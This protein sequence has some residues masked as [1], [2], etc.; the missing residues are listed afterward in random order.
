[1]IERTA[2]LLWRESG[3][4]MDGFGIPVEDTRQMM[5]DYILRNCP[6]TPNQE[7]SLQLAQDMRIRLGI[8]TVLSE[9]P[10]RSINDEET[11]IAMLSSIYASDGTDFSEESGED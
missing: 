10:A 11:E 5:Y 8:E 1:M 4:D 2:F 9:S 7:G 3:A 6:I